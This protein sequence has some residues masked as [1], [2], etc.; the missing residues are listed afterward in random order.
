M[1]SNSKIPACLKVK[2]H[3]KVCAAGSVVLLN[4]DTQC[5]YPAVRRLPTQL[6]IKAHKYKQ[7]LAAVLGSEK[8]KIQQLLHLQA[9]LAFFGQINLP[10]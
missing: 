5:G 4:S 10:R 7:A 8:M 2:V 9:P 3:K 6:S 1:G